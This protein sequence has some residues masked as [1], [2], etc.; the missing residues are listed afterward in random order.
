MSR[1]FLTAVIFTILLF[2]SGAQAQLTMMERT[3]ELQRLDIFLGHWKR[4]ADTPEGNRP[5][6]VTAEIIADWGP[7]DVWMTWNAVIEF[8]TGD[9][10]FGRRQIAW[11]AGRN[12]YQS[13][14]IDTQSAEVIKGTAQW[15]ES[16][17][18]QIEAEPIQWSDG[19][20][21]RFK[22]EYQPISA[23]EIRETGWRSVDD[24]DYQIHAEAV[25]K[26]AE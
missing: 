8:N 4:S 9:T 2:S 20:S 17:A 3:P 16:G 26:K 25:W 19:R 15:T 5:H 23:T 7:A 6:P 24:G 11:D 21:Y 12:S 10:L 1:F 14:W 13:S 18:F 22:T